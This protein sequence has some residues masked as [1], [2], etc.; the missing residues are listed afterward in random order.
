MTRLL[1][2][3]CR[4]LFLI[5]ASVHPGF[6][7]LRL[8]R[9]AADFSAG[10]IVFTKLHEDQT[11]DEFV[12][13]DYVMRPMD[14]QRGLRRIRVSHWLR[15]GTVAF[16][17]SRQDGDGCASR[18]SISMAPTSGARGGCGELVSGRTSHHF[19]ARV[20]EASGRLDY[21]YR[22]HRPH[23]LTSCSGEACGLVANG[24]KIAFQSNRSGNQEIWIMDA[25]GSNYCPAI[26]SGFRPDWSRTG[27]SSSS[28]ATQA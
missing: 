20:W 16:V 17:I 6:P 25:D 3:C 21:R 27:S 23:D 10:V 15:G 13:A 9:F 8:W 11:Q 18:W 24:Q 5:A 22:R 2:A 14:R 12:V 4:T 7:F 28:R 26:G 19:N 1:S